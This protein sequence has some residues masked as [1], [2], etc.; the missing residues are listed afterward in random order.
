MIILIIS[1]NH[2]QAGNEGDDKHHVDISPPFHHPFRI[3]ESNGSS[4][5]CFGF[6]SIQTNLGQKKTSN[7]IGRSRHN[8]SVSL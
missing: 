4:L 7:P 5:V 6:R 3:L 1:P 2:Q 8:D